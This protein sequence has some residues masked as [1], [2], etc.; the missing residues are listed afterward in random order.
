MTSKDIFIKALLVIGAAIAGLVAVAVV[1][2]AKASDLATITA[3]TYKLYEGDRGICSVTFLKNDTDGA[4]FLTAAHCVDGSNF[5]IRKQ[6]LD[7][8]NLRDVLSEEI[9]YVKAVRTLVKKDIA[10]IQLTNKDLKISAPTVDIATVEEAKALK[11]GDQ[12]IAV[13]YPAASY[14]SVTNGTFVGKVPQVFPD[15]DQDTPM[16]QTTVP[17]AGGNS[18]GALYALFPTGDDP[19]PGKAYERVEGK[20]FTWKLIGTTTGMR[21]DNSVMTWFQTSETVN[22]ALKGYVNKEKFEAKPERPSQMGID[23]R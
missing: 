17:V 12:L 10:V 19:V 21:T 9:Y 11:T 4:L 18:G 1:N 6:V 23:Q 13:G 22:E 15:L 3:A 7:P 16:Y 8:K 14:V 5:N 2:P 20:D